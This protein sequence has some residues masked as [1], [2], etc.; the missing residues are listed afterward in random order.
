MKKRAT[1]AVALMALACNESR[2]KSA[3]DAASGA[4]RTVADSAMAMGKS[5]VDSAK[6]GVK[7]VA[8]S[9]MAQGGAMVDSAAAKMG[10]VGAKAGE[11]VKS[12]VAQAAGAVKSGAAK[13]A[14]AAQGA[15]AG[16]AAAAA[17]A[18]ASTHKSFTTLTR[19]QKQQLQTAL[20]GDGCNASAVDGIIGPRTRA[21]IACSTKKHTI[22]KGDVAA[23]YQALNL[24][25]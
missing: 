22:A 18:V 11:A 14:G 19:D 21:A 5:A 1:V 9:A 8:D 25:F 16:A 10:A 23:L 13:A 20:N 24:R 4:A 2:K 3:M 6:A 17:A 12:G 7:G 15:A